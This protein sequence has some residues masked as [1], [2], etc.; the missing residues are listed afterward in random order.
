MKKI[1]FISL[2]ACVLLLLACGKEKKNERHII[3][4]WDI[5]RCDLDS[6]GRLVSNDH[7]TE[8]T[9][10]FMDDDKFRHLW[11]VDSLRT[12][13]NTNVT[14]INRTTGRWDVTETSL[15]MTYD[16]F[17]IINVLAGIDS[18]KE[19]YDFVDLDKENII[20]LEGT[21][22]D[23]SVRISGKYSLDQ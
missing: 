3:G 9:F 21:I 6:T 17:T 20:E 5:E 12:S 22:N 23:K 7:F 15:I 1:I 13:D 14:V 19:Q 10:E 18:L 16:S 8:I 11:Q 4:K 2:T